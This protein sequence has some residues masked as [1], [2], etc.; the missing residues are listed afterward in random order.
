M[1]RFDSTSH[2]R[3][4]PSFPVVIQ[5]SP[6]GTLAHPVTAASC[7]CSVLGESGWPSG[8]RGA[9]R[10]DSASLALSEGFSLSNTRVFF[11][12]ERV[13][14]GASRER[15]GGRGQRRVQ[16]REDE[17]FR[18]VPSGCET[19]D[20]MTRPRG[21][22]RADARAYLKGV[23]PHDSASVASRARLHGGLRL[24]AAGVR[25]QACARQSAS[26]ASRSKR[27][28]ASGRENNGFPPFDF[29]AF[30]RNSFLR[31]RLE[32]PTVLLSQ[33]SRPRR[34]ALAPPPSRRASRP[35][36]RA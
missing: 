27:D 32:A 2:S 25:E 11:G 8:A 1:F 7:A 31:S 14:G 20:A 21:S 17:M 9:R 23:V 29:R 10:S 19:R 15:R 5:Y 16:R 30:S 22:D 26:Y 33:R 34:R 35:S 3:G 36:P 6:P 18:D 24:H 28:R 4:R 13:R 12:S